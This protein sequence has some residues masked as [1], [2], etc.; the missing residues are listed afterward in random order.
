MGN[1]GFVSCKWSEAQKTAFD[2]NSRVPFWIGNLPNQIP[3][4]T[5]MPQHSEWRHDYAPTE[6]TKGE[7]GAVQDAHPCLLICNNFHKEIAHEKQ[8]L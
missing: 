3:M 6:G 8:Y 5:L 4:I 2:Q 1:I 7:V